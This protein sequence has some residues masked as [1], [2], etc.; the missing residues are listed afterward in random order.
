[1]KTGVNALVHQPGWQ[2][3][4]DELAAVVGAHVLR[5]AVQGEQ[6]LQVPADLRGA[7]AARHVTAERLP[8]VLVDDVQD[9]QRTPSR[10]GRS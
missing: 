3:V 10:S 9:P 2:L 5:L 4:G 1:M 7:D 6:L 8:G